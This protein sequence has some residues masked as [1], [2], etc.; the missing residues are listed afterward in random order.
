MVDS[1]LKLNYVGGDTAKE[2]QKIKRKT[3]FTEQVKKGVIMLEVGAF[4]LEI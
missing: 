2:R 1:K 3:M 4:I